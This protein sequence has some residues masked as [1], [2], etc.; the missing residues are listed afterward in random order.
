MPRM[1]VLTC[2]LA[3]KGLSFINLRL[4]VSYLK[5]SNLDWGGFEPRSLVALRAATSISPSVSVL[6]GTDSVSLIS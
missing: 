5:S 3:K 6:Q 2:F 4:K 1:W